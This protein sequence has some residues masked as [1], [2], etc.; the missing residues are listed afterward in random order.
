[1]HRRLRASARLRPALL[2]A[3]LGV[4]FLIV[5][6]MAA[7]TDMNDWNLTET[8]NTYPTQFHVSTG[9]STIQY[10]WLDSPNKST[11]ISSNACSDMS[12]LGAPS[13]YGVGDTAYHNVGSSPQGSCFYVR[14]RTAAGQGSMSLHDGRVNR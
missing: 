8:V 14:G 3:T 6:A 9:G 13:S 2:A 4:L 7:T 5:P 10:R 11:V 12:V 1:M